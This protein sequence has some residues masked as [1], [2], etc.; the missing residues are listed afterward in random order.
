MTTA[1]NI[2]SDHRNARSE[3]TRANI[4]NALLHLLEEG[5]HQPCA[6]LVA[7]RANVSVRALFNHFQNMEGL[8]TEVVDSQ[9]RHI[10]GLLDVVSTRQSTLSKA[11]RVVAM[12]DDFHSLAVPLH[13][14]VRFNSAARGWTQIGESLQQLRRATST[15]I[16]QSFA[17]EISR[18]RDPHDVVPRLEAVISFE[19][20]DHFRRVQGC[21]RHATRTHVLALLMDVLEA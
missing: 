19:L 2:A 13:N 11:R 1:W 12:H 5:H 17:R 8:Y 16:Q 6:Q 15:Q 21:T 18:C 20:W 4:S 3:R 7:K 10:I 14:C 9:T